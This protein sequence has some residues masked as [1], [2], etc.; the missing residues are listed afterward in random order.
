VLVH[1]M[2]S[3][4]LAVA[5]GFAAAGICSSGYRLC[6]NSRLVFDRSAGSEPISTLRVALLVVAGP[7]VIMRNAWRA[8]LGGR[9]RGWLL[10]SALVASGWSFCL[11]LVVLNLVV[12]LGGGAG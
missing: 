6:T 11:G 5:M 8:A 10:A 12:A 1:D 7:L 3:V 2:V 9:P 4:L